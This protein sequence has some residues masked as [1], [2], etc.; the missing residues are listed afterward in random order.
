MSS[1][2]C[3]PCNIREQALPGVERNGNEVRVLD[4]NAPEDEVERG[5]GSSV[6]ADGPGNMLGAGDGGNAGRNDRELGLLRDPQQRQDGLEQPDGA[7]DVDV[8]VLDQVGC[9]GHGD[10]E[11]SLGFEDTGIRDHDIKVRDALAFDG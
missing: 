6:R 8:D 4:V 5:F 9:L 2:R 7:V 10:L 11:E 1:Q 3:L